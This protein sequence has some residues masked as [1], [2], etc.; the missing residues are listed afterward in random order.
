MAQTSVDETEAREQTHERKTRR[1]SRRSQ[2]GSSARRRQ[3]SAGL[4]GKSGQRSA[5]T[6][7][8]GKRKC[9]ESG[10]GREKQTGTLGRESFVGNAQTKS[11]PSSYRKPLDGQKVAAPQSALLQAD[12]DILGAH[13]APVRVSI[14]R[15]REE[16][17]DLAAA[18][19]R[20]D[21]SAAIY[22]HAQTDRSGWHCTAT[23]SLSISSCDG[24]IARGT[25]RSE[26]RS[27]RC[28]VP[29]R[30]HAAG[31]PRCV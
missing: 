17:A 28:D 4:N 18:W 21:T 8:E 12:A 19:V 24:R 6:Y 11:A 30:R 16:D 7:S 23:V 9:A 27:R 29:D 10:G 13:D 14:E 2:R 20:S 1:S 15:E 5:R 26:E 31:R 22:C 25:G 3:R